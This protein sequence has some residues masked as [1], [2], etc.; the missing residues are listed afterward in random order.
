[1]LI[2]IVSYHGTSLS[3]ATTISQKGFI[4]S[5]AQTVPSDLGYGVYTYIDLADP[6]I[7]FVDNAKKN[8]S[9]YIELFKNKRWKNQK[10]A[11]IEVTSTFDENKIL[12]FNDVKVYNAFLINYKRLL[13]IA[14]SKLTTYRPGPAQ[15]RRQVDGIVIEYLISHHLIIDPDVIIMD[16]HTEFQDVKSNFHNGTE[17]VIR[18]QSVIDNVKL[19]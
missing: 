17:F 3:N 4:I 6:T 13:N 2:T 10:T 19:V 15:K 12:N 1:M 8:A 9:H 5:K 11:I 16:T 18:K 14:L 7:K